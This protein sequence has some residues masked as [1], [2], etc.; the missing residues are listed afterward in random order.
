M[1]SRVSST[2]RSLLSKFLHAGIDDHTPAYLVDRVVYSN[3]VS[4]IGTF[5]NL[6]D[7]RANFSEH[8]PF[9]LFWNCLYEFA[10]I[11]CWFLNRRKS[12][13]AGRLILI[14]VVFLGIVTTSAAQGPA[15]QSEHFLLSLAALAFTLFHP[16]ERFWA[17]LFGGLCAISF[18]YFVHQTGPTLYVPFGHGRF[19]PADLALNQT[20]Y[21]LLF[22]LSL[23]ALSNAY[24]RAT[25]V[26]DEQRAKLFEANKMA[27]LG[28]MAGGMA[29]E[30]NNPLAIVLALA[31]RLA[32]QAKAEQVSKEEI[33]KTT[34]RI[35]NT[36]FRIV[37][38]VRGLQVLSRDGERLP[39]ATSSI[40]RIIDDTV[41]LCQE[42]FRSMD[43]DFSV[44]KDCPGTYVFCRSVQI[45]QALLNL[46]NNACDATS[47]QKDKWIEV[48]ARETETSVEI[49]IRNSGEKISSEVQ[50][51]LFQPFFT[52]KGVGRGT[53]L[54]L[55]ISLAML[56]EHGGSIYFDE[57][58]SY[59]RFVMILPKQ[60]VPA[61]S[62][63]S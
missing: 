46:L 33:V 38:I 53:G 18:L 16:S 45:S 13:L 35:Q 37:D 49:S 52:T 5:I 1:A 20:S 7:A 29:H 44:D 48:S 30:I 6:L 62:L 60:R 4:L 39:F 19:S 40:E 56:R 32:R 15:L 24:A 58:D 57:H 8:Y 14:T 63:T 43:I 10:L 36:A 23:F 2:A 26:S 41:S 27:S 50:R 22:V 61:P 42:R 25:K 9:L 11:G 21:T 47:G 54:G 17:R 28:Q 31:E 3:W 55:S 34:D 59:T 51:K 12:Y